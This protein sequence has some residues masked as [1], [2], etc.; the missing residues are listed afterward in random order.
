MQSQRSQ[1]PA[2]EGMMQQNQEIYQRLDRLDTR[3]LALPLL[4]LFEK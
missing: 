2:A 1:I 4:E 3:F